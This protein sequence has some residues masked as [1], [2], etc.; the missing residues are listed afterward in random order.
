MLIFFFRKSCHL[1]DNME[2]I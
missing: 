2:K 1:C